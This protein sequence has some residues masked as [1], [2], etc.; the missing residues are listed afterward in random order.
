MRDAVEE[1]GC[2]FGP[3]K[4]CAPFFEFK[5]CGEDDRRCLVE[6]SDEVKE[7]PAAG[8]GERDV[9]KFIHDDTIS[10]HELLF[11]PAG[12]AVTFLFDEQVDE[13]NTVEEL[14]FTSPLDQLCAKGCCDVSFACSCS[15][16]KDQI[17]PCR[18]WMNC[19]VQS[20]SICAFSTG[21]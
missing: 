3:T 17:M 4:N 20:W 18:S 9:S 11:D 19:P 8:L 16:N 15:A 21:I 7:Q 12:F 14:D 10:G 2:H 5:V 13:I 6:F 1:C